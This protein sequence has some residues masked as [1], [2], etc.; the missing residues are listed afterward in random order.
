MKIHVLKPQELSSDLVA[1]WAEIQSAQRA[2][3]SPYFRP[4]FT[5]AV[6]RV[7]PGV[8]I[9]LLEEAGQAVGFF[10][11]ERT[12]WSGARPVGGQLSD[13]HGVVALPGTNWTAEQLL[14]DCR[15]STWSFHHLITDQPQFA[16]HQ[17][18]AQESVYLDLSEG[19]E[20]YR[21]ARRKAG[22]DKIG[23]VFQSYRKVEREIGPVRFVPVV[24]EESVFAWLLAHKSEQYRRTGITD[25]FR[26]DWT[27]RLL[28]DLWNQ[29]SDDFRG[30][31]SGLYFGERLVAAHFGLRCRG[32]LHSWFP[33]YD[34]E[35]SK[36]SPGLMMTTLLAREFAELGVTRIDLGKGDEAYKRHFRSA[37]EMLAE[38]AAT[39]NS[40][41]RSVHHQLSSARRWAKRHPL[42]QQLQTPLRWYRQFRDWFSLA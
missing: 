14:R 30:V 13:F 24:E 1:R 21:L 33:A 10:P 5:Q 9:G 3:Q 41:A 32:V 25:L 12:G 38:G 19:F 22:S 11:Y 17:L 7:R 23:Q 8:E 29:P 42:T 26:Y 27:V 6:A 15:L 35:Y 39:G 18:A 31:L 34:R 37:G 16:Q 36:N 2:F 40:L 20:A 4:E 28:R